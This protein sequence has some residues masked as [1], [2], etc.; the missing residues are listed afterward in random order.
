MHF[1]R[2]SVNNEWEIAKARDPIE[3]R[4][5][6]R[7]DR[8][9]VPQQ[10]DMKKPEVLRSW[11][12]RLSGFFRITPA[13]VR[14]RLRLV[15]GARTIR[16]SG[17]FD[18]NFYLKRYPDVAAVG[19]DP[20]W[21]YLLWGASEGRDPHPDFDTS[22]YVESHPEIACSDDNPLVHYLQGA[23]EGRPTQAGRPSPSQS[24]R[25]VLP[26][27]NYAAAAT[28]EFSGVPKSDDI[29]DQDLRPSQ[30]RGEVSCPCCGQP[31]L[32]NYETT[33]DIDGSTVEIAVCTVCCALV[34]GAALREV[35]ERTV[36]PRDV[37]TRGLESV[38]PPESREQMLH[39]IDLF[40]ETV[41]FLRD[42]S[43]LGERLRDMV[44]LEFGIGRGYLMIAASDFFKRSYG[45]DLRLDIFA[46]T[47]AEIGQPAN[48]RVVTDVNQI[49]EPVDVVF[50]W[51]VME[52]LPKARDFLEYARSLM[53]NGGYVFFQVPLYRPDV[54][55]RSHYTFFNSRSVSVMAE[56]SGFV[57]HDIWFD[58]PN[59]F[60]TCLLRTREGEIP[61]L[62]RT[63]RSD[64]T[65]AWRSVSFNSRDG[66]RYWWHRLPTSSY[67][68]PIYA[69]LSDEEWQVIDDWF[70][71]TDQLYSQGTGECSVPA[72][73][74]LQGLIMGSGM[75]RI[76]Q[77]G[78][79]I[80]YSTLLIG[81]MLRRMNRTRGLLSIDISAPVTE[82]AAKWVAKAGLDEQV[83]LMVSDSANPDLPGIVRQYFGGR[84][85][86]LVF[87][88]SS[89]QYEHTL[90]EL[91]LWYRILMPGGLLLL[92]DMSRFAAGFD[93][94]GR[95]GVLRA[96]SE[97]S[98]ANGISVL[99]MG[100]FIDGSLREHAYGDS[101]GLGI[102]QKSVPRSV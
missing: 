86:E 26:R 17:L 93:S 3:R 57:V 12:Q 60:M 49:G 36:D 78:H 84:D 69:T 24:G 71:E 68:P 31:G 83:S 10:A 14:R 64:G 40:R 7:T 54:V 85:P 63:R 23:G 43:R 99:G 38:Y 53:P 95:G 19:I 44:S 55:V 5:D 8:P 56:A 94:T 97:W 77:C 79:F 6:R 102:I 30:Q 20:V 9:L 2:V 15:K 50:L 11:S 76:V 35:F 21:H 4:T 48:V 41:A 32:V 52:H 96:V 45:T 29:W 101:C 92:H 28:G 74:M 72:M 80:G 39:S 13:K 67:V 61:V 73:C 81:F 62:E 66:N 27:L 65:Q 22:V 46:N 51:H 37:Q 33:K 16:S 59:A 1:T 58:L 25:E 47:V 88:D 75:T 18:A 34:N 42:Q 98:V 89:H 87:I 90:A 82:Y 70:T 100:G 91:D